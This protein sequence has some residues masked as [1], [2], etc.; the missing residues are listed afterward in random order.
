MCFGS[1]GNARRAIARGGGL[2][3]LLSGPA[4]SLDPELEANRTRQVELERPLSSREVGAKDC[5]H[6]SDQEQRPRL[7]SRLGDEHDD[8]DENDEEPGDEQAEA[9]EAFGDALAYRLVT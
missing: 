9:D 8:A 6:G 1:F 3:V 2:A 4:R 5:E 7:P